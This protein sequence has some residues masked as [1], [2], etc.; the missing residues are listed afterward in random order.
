MIEII[1]LK[2]NKTESN[3]KK[4]NSITSIRPGYNFTEVW[5]KS[6]VLPCG[7]KS[8]LWLTDNSYTDIRIKTGDQQSPN[9]IYLLVMHFTNKNIVNKKN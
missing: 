9:A 4:K 6:R 2:V 7:A 3:Y 8:G 1:R 5:Q